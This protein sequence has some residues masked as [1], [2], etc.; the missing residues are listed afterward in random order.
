[1]LRPVAKNPAGTT[2]NPTSSAVASVI[3]TLP[4]WS[5]K[6]SGAG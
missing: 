1:M 5:K 4:K 6:L 2:N 3:W